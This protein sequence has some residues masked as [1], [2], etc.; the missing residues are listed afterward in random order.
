M[1]VRFRQVREDIFIFE[2]WVGDEVVF[3]TFGFC[4]KTVFLW[5]LVFTG[6]ADSAAEYFIPLPVDLPALTFPAFL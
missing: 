6:I 5:K 4:E 3:F 2:F 1:R